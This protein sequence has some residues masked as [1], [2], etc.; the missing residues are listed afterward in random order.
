V[1]LCNEMA[2]SGGDIFP[3]IFKKHKVGKLVG[4]RTWGAMISSYGFQVIDGGSV[5]APDDAMV[6]VAT[7]DWCIENEGVTPDISVELDPYLWRQGRDAQLEAAVEQ[8]KK[9]LLS[10]VPVKMDRPKYPIKTKLPG[11]N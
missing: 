1:M 5:R 7:G 9:D 4:K 6:D 11:K 10:Y 8:I 3:Y 2:G